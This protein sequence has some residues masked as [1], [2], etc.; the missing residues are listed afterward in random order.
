MK[1]KSTT[2]RFKSIHKMDSF[3]ESRDLSSLFK[4]GEVVRPL[5][6]KINLDIPLPV[7]KKIDQIA[8]DI[9]IARQPLIKI[10]LY[11]KIREQL[12][13]ASV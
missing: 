1:K 7:L 13:V 5:V 2:K 12:A 8:S 10:W 6:K 11:E 9:G 3:L 4:Q